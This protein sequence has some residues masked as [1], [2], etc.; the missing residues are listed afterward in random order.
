[1]D[2]NNWKALKPAAQYVVRD[3]L[4]EELQTLCRT[5]MQGSGEAPSGNFEVVVGPS[6]RRTV[7]YIDTYGFR[8]RSSFAAMRTHEARVQEVQNRTKTMNS[9]IKTKHK[10]LEKMSRHIANNG[11]KKNPLVALHLTSW[12]KQIRAMK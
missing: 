9:D 11:G 10:M 12:S 3:R 5:Y 1:M 4:L 7:M 6:G 8:A 2:F